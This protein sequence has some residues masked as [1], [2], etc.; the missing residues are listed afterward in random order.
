MLEYK[1][2]QTA[3]LYPTAHAVFDRYV[4]EAIADGWEPKGGIAI[5][6]GVDANGQWLLFM[7]QAMTRECKRSHS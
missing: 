1:T 3:C 4:N 2:V 7:A 5:H 6:Q